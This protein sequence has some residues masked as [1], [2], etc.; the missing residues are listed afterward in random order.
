VPEYASGPGRQFQVG[1]SKLMQKAAWM[2][3]QK[4]GRRSEE[5]YKLYVDRWYEQHG[6]TRLGTS[7]AGPPRLPRA[8]MPVIWQQLG[9]LQP[10]G[11]GGSSR[12]SKEDAMAAAVARASAAVAP[13]VPTSSTRAPTTRTD[14]HDPA[15]S[16]RLAQAYKCYVDQKKAAPGV[17]PKINQLCTAFNIP[18]ATFRRVIENEGRP[19]G[20]SSPKPSHP[21]VAQI[22][23]C[24]CL[25]ILWC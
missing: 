8:P 15:N 23:R 10:A 7:P 25:P 1:A 2:K 11:G 17:Q 19:A 24:P 22:P 9:L 4:K 13:H 18:P 6:V 16:A 12:A 21:A 3:K 20:E 5:G 14:W